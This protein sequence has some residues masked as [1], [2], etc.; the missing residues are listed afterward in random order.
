MK[1]RFGPPPEG[2]IAWHDWA[3]AQTNTGNKQ[4]KC[5]NCNLWFFP[6]EKHDEENCSQFSKKPYTLPRN[7]HAMPEQP[8]Q[9]IKELEAHVAGLDKR[10][11]ELV[12]FANS[13]HLELTRYQ[14]ALKRIMVTEPL[15]GVAYMIAHEALLSL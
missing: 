5:P 15:G 6:S 13:Q 1:R 7:H 14:N 8:A 12:V 10:I 9:R 2:Y 4:K 11:D 3:E